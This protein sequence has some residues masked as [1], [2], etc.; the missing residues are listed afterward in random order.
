MILDQRIYALWAECLKDRS[1]PVARVRYQR[2]N[3][4]RWEEGECEI[5]EETLEAIANA[6]GISLFPPPVLPPHF[7]IWGDPEKLGATRFALF[8]P[9]SS[10]AFC[11]IYIRRTPFANGLGNLTHFLGERGDYAITVLNEILKVMATLSPQPNIV[12]VGPSGGGKT[13]LMLYYISLLAQ[14]ISGAIYV[15]GVP[16]AVGIIRRLFGEKCFTFC[17]TPFGLYSPAEIAAYSQR[18]LWTAIQMAR[19][20]S[21][22]LV[23]FQEVH[24]VPTGNT[25]IEQ[26]GFIPEGI[27]QLLVTSGIPVAAT[28]HHPTSLAA[29]DVARFVSTHYGPSFASLC[30]VILVGP[31]RLSMTWVSGSTTALEFYNKEAFRPEVYLVP[32]SIL[33]TALA[34]KL[35]E[36][37]RR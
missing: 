4:Y 31:G 14:R 12:F 34:E 30:C 23:I 22:E 5:D 20:T 21:P 11:T 13:N 18:A 7:A 35:K 3:I 32:H 6:T 2:M 24:S 15:E 28:A 17:L 26:V 36:L 29:S 8:P 19:T 16:E 33:P 9:Q 1:K 27:I 10:D 37:T 25:A